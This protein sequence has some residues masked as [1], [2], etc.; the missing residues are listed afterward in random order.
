MIKTKTGIADLQGIRTERWLPAPRVQTL[1]A[2]AH[3]TPTADVA[4]HME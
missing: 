1:L 4:F 3:S 2:I